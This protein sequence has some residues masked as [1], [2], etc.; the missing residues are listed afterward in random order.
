MIGNQAGIDSLMLIPK[1]LRTKSDAGLSYTEY[2]AT[3]T[4]QQLD[5]WQAFEKQVALRDE[6]RALLASFTRPMPVL[7]TSG[8]W[9][10]DCVAQVPMLAA[11][12]AANPGIISLRV[13]DRDE[14][15]D[16]SEQV[17]ICGGQRVPTVIFLNEL[18]EFVG[19]YG[20]RTLARYRAIA[21]KQLGGA[22][23]LPG[24]PIPADEIAATLQDWVD[25]FERVQLMLRVSP[26]LRQLHSD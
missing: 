11:I 22:C 5:N 26:K 17:M 24:A 9:C 18:F 2:L 6:Q 1:Y 14:H 13:L 12:E 20:D 7:C 10:G 16:L 19:L 25:E 8:T 3:A 23:P 21:A 15:A 4:P